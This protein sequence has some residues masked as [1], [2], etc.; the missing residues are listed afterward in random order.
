[1]LEKDKGKSDEA[2]SPHYDDDIVVTKSRRLHAKKN[3][4]DDK[5]KSPHYD[6]VGKKKSMR[7]FV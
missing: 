1:V 3:V 4:V 6:K 5:F 2:K 7:F